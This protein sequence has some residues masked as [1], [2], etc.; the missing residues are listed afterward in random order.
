MELPRD[1]LRGDHYSKK[2]H[3]HGMEGDDGRQRRL[4]QLKKGF[5]HA[6]V[7]QERFSHVL[8]QMGSQEIEERDGGERK[9]N[10]RSRDLD[11]FSYGACAH[12][13]ST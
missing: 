6:P 7:E 9:K 11:K 5:V 12:S 2:V 10:E 4:P 13:H 3:G 8:G 1:G